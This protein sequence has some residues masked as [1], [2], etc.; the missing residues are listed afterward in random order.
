[1]KY[2]ARHLS[3]LL[4]SVMIAACAGTPG[5]VSQSDPVDEISLQHGV[6]HAAAA[7]SRLPVA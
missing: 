2:T 7:K 4:V 6:A 5:K 3:A 1:M